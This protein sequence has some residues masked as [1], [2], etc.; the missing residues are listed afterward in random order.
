MQPI[1]QHGM[2]YVQR[3]FRLC[4][5]LLAVAG[6]T[7]AC[8]RPL[9]R[10]PAAP[11]ISLDW[12]CVVPTAMFGPLDQDLPPSM[13]VRDFHAAVGRGGRVGV[14][15][16]RQKTSSEKTPPDQ[17][18]CMAV[19]GSRGVERAAGFSGY[20]PSGWYDGMRAAAYL[21]ERWYGL[22]TLY[23]GMEQ[24]YLHHSVA[25]VGFDEDGWGQ[26]EEVLDQ[27]V[28]LER[29][30]MHAEGETLHLF[31][32]ESYLPLLAFPDSGMER[33][34]L[35]GT[36][37]RRGGRGRV[38]TL[39]DLPKRWG[40]YELA[41]CLPAGDSRFTFL[42]A[43]R[44]YGG[45]QPDQ[46][47]TISVPTTW[48]AWPAPLYS[49][50]LLAGKSICVPL[51]GGRGQFVGLHERFSRT[52]VCATEDDAVLLLGAD[53]N[54]QDWASVREIARGRDWSAKSVAVR[55]L[56]A[57]SA[58]GVLA[59][60]RGSGGR[61][62]YA[63]GTGTGTWSDPVETS[64]VVGNEIWIGGEGTTSTLLTRM[65]GNLYWCRLDLTAN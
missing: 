22:V 43:Y 14:V 54:G 5:G 56:Q 41:G 45:R 7:G 58:E 61:L 4:V 62:T 37:I 52:R 10:G 21:N 40:L 16:N 30:Q 17:L 42:F 12:H 65:D 8:H 46:L 2:Q 53:V 55:V 51:S 25:L 18:T 13:S 31:W 47:A 3:G 35:M 36:T 26:P 15:W 38:V 9:E 32:L 19:I 57:G 33:E 23:H 27:H 60:W 28:P 1:R 64:L 49:Q 20:P 11:P 34:R 39:Y 59:V 44:A 29:A 50:Y 63:I 24:P 48:F 6:L